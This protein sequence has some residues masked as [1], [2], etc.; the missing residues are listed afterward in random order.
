MKSSLS[1]VTLTCLFALFTSFAQS[2]PV[3]FNFQSTLM[4][5]ATQVVNAGGQT[6]GNVFDA[7]YGAG[8][9]AAGQLSLSGSLTY[10]NSTPFYQTS[11]PVGNGNF[12]LPITGLQLSI[13]GIAVNANIASIN[14]NNN[15]SVLGVGITNELTCIGDLAGCAANQP[16]VTM[17]QSSNSALIGNSQVP[18]GTDS[19]FFILGGTGIANDFSPAFNAGGL[20]DVFVDGILLGFGSSSTP[21]WNSS[22]TLPG[23]NSFFDPATFE[24]SSVNVLFNGASIEAFGTAGTLAPV[25]IPAAVWLFGSGLLGL[26]GVARRRRS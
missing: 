8:T 5:D 9:G 7:I 15:S 16:G 20:G 13:G 3:T 22:T 14:A 17:K 12:L 19:L 21:L 26:V 11:T 6:V 1:K 24:F 10:D 23:T 18:G 25:P 2:A 4:F